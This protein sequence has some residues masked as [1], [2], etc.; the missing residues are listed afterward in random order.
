MK[1]FAA[2]ASL[3]L[4]GTVLATGIATAGTPKPTALTA[5][6][7]H[8]PKISN[9]SVGGSADGVIKAGKPM[10]KAK[11]MVSNMSVSHPVTPAKMKS[12]MQGWKKPPQ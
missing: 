8:K 11:P 6:I 5:L 2:L 12:A 9:M 7:G 4:A 1:R 3:A 10:G